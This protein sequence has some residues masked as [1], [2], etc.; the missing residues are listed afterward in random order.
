MPDI[1]LVLPLLVPL[2][3][4]CRHTELRCL[5]FVID[6]RHESPPLGGISKIVA[7]ASGR[8]IDDPV[9]S[10]YSTSNSAAIMIYTSSA[11]TDVAA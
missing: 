4:Y 3:L 5:I 10:A 11:I 9:S 8:L 6:R 7:I 1:G 2:P